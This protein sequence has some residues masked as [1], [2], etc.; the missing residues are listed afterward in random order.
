LIAKW[1]SQWFSFY[2]CWIVTCT[3]SMVNDK[4]S[5]RKI[6]LHV[7]SQLILH[8]FTTC[9]SEENM[10]P[11]LFY[12]FLSL[13]PTPLTISSHLRGA[14]GQTQIYARVIL[15]YAILWH[16]QLLIF[17][18]SS[19]LL[20]LHFFPRRIALTKWEFLLSFVMS[21]GACLTMSF[22]AIAMPFRLLV[23]GFGSEAYFLET[24]FCS[25]LL[26]QFI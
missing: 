19:L 9:D 5:F 4:K 21:F 20:L 12:A 24:L 6:I 14:E 17:T 13:S 23:A 26:L 2:Y 1:H 11:C 8:Y 15:F 7:L 25:R 16:E 10:C 18:L 22:R 3:L